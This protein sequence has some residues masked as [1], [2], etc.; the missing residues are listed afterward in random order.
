MG[1]RDHPEFRYTVKNYNAV[2][3]TKDKTTG[4]LKK[5][6]RLKYI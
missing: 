2:N 1:K 6:S 5:A 3:D 4:L